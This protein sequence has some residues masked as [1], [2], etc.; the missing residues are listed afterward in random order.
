[1]NKLYYYVYILTNQHNTVPYIGVTRDL[2]RRIYQHKNKA[3]EGFTKKYNLN[4][5]VYYEIFDDINIAITREKTLKNLVRRKKIT[6]IESKNPL[7]KNLYNEIL[8]P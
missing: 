6:L 2:L 3:I 1:M 4:K 5:L 7:W 8:S